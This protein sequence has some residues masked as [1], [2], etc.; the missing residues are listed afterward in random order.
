[1]PIY[2]YECKNGHQ[3][4]ELLGF[5]APATKKCLECGLR[6][7]KMISL[8]AVHFKGEGFYITDSKKDETTKSKARAKDTSKGK[9]TKSDSKEKSSDT[10]SETKKET[11]SSETKSSKKKKDS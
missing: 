11:K 2:E 4:E 8:S 7:K 10:K 5:D 6:A 3:F 1:M 9:E